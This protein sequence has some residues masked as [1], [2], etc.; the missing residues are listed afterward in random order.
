V[1]AGKK[2]KPSKWPTNGAQKNKKVYT[3][4]VE[5]YSTATVVKY[6]S[7]RTAYGLLQFYEMRRMDKS[8]GTGSRS[9]EG[10]ESEC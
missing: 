3:H 7:Q 5:Y 1:D 9:L 6:R 4:T 8:T 10:V 2:R